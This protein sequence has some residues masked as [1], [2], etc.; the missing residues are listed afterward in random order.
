MVSALAFA[1]SVEGLSVPERFLVDATYGTCLSTDPIEVSC[2][3]VNN[4]LGA[5]LG[6][7]W[8]LIDA[9]GLRM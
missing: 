4:C 9:K 5:S 1:S 7:V 3:E 6:L 8:K 2:V